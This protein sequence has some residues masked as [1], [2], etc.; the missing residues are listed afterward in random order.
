MGFNAYIIRLSVCRRYAGEVEFQPNCR[1]DIC[2]GGGQGPHGFDVLFAQHAAVQRGGSPRPVAGTE[3]AEKHPA[4]D[5]KTKLDDHAEEFDVQE[6][7]VG[8]ASR[9]LADSGGRG[10]P[11]VSSVGYAE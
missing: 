10:P 5:V 11:L 7:V 8:R 1:H 6:L 4:P 2:P 3:T 9:G